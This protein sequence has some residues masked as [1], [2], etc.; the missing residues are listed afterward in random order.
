MA[1]KELY[2]MVQEH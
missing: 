2:D 1:A